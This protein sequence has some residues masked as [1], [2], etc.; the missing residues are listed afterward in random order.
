MPDVLEHDLAGCSALDKHFTKDAVLHSFQDDG[1]NVHTD[2]SCSNVYQRA[3]RNTT[4]A[5]LS[6]VNTK[7]VAG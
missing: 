6:Q 7:L 2:M 1:K 4:T 5:P 3:L